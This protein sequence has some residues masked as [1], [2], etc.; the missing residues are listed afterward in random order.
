[1]FGYIL[2]FSAVTPLIG[3]WLME[4]GEFG[5]SI[6][7]AGY[8]NGAGWAFLLCWLLLVAVAWAV[9]TFN[10]PR[11]NGAVQVAVLQDEAFQRYARNLIVLDTTF[12][13]V[14]LFVF[15][16]IDVIRGTVDK[17]EF[18]VLLGPY[19]AIA[20]ML[21]KFIVPALIGYA[22]LLYR[23]SSPSRT[24]AALFWINVLIVV[25]IGAGWGTKSTSAAMLIPAALF[26][27]WRP[28][29]RVIIVLAALV[30][31]SFV[32]FSLA[33]DINSSDLATAINFIW[34]RLTVL[35]G[36]V[37]WL[38]W[39][40]VRSGAQMP[41]YWPTLL[42]VFGDRTLTVFGLDAANYSQWVDYHY[43]LMA[44]E[45]VGAPLSEIETGYSI[46]GTFF[47]EGLIAGGRLGAV[48]FAVIGGV[49]VGTVYR[50][51]AAARDANRPLAATMW[52]TYFASVV[53]PWLTSGGLTNYVHVAT[54]VGVLCSAVAL[55][56]VWKVHF[57][58]HL[59]SGTRPT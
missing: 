32:A 50:K 48:L 31:I 28:G 14:H 20:F 10:R 18:K 24:N 25:V 59:D 34:V 55:E 39:E 37:P 9:A 22:A 12:L 15:G 52:A 27:Y 38:A 42:A 49:A 43:G 30:L 17:G 11:G 35:Q 58:V 21:V 53:F 57:R 29:V 36:D 19:G 33:F 6:G 5:P 54:L 7:G 41:N 47:T 51:M 56:I 4:S 45:F 44:T 13:F 2:F 16:G 8:P 46:T 23:T 26:L 3:I 40:Q 1:M